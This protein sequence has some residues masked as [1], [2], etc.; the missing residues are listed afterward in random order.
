M[1]DALEI[2]KKGIIKNAKELVLI[3]EENL[4]LHRA[5]KELSS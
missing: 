2:L 5:N 4:K 1:L 3:R